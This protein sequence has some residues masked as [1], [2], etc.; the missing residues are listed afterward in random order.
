TA[1]ISRVISPS[2]HTKR[3]F[4]TYND[5][6]LSSDIYHRLEKITRAEVSVR[7]SSSGD[8]IAP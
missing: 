1:I 2:K 8:I 4:K 5:C 3:F 7:N 6:L